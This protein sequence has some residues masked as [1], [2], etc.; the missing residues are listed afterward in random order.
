MI[1]VMNPLKYWNRFVTSAASVSSLFT[2]FLI[3]PPLV[4]RENTWFTYGK[5]L[6]AVCIGLWFV[7]TAAWALKKHRWKWWFTG[8]VLALCSF[9]SV[10]S[11]LELFG[12]WT[13]VYWHA[14]RVVIGQTLTK[15][16]EQ[17][18]ERLRRDRPSATPLDLLW[19]TAGDTTRVWVE[20][21][22]KDRQHRLTLLYLLSVLLLASTVVT[23]SQA[24][25]CA[26]K[27]R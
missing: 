18:L 25:Y 7:P 4:G 3:S 17:D 24:A 12:A 19:K 5:F 9:V 10:F 13:T 21:E 2:G 26:S 11:Y 6:V 23:T 1:A 16:A 15:C 27:N 20:S 14:Q 22:I 8:C